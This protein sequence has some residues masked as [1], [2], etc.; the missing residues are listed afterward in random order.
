MKKYIINFALA[1]IS[2]SLGGTALFLSIIL[3]D[4]S[5]NNLLLVM[6]SGSITSLGIFAM[7]NIPK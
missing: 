4:G 6:L 7:I 1:S 3:K 2:V 5:I